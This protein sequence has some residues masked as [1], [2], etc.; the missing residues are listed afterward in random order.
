MFILSIVFHLSPNILIYVIAT[1]FE[2]QATT[3]FSSESQ[4]KLPENVQQSRRETV[5]IKIGGD[6]IPLSELISEIER[7][8][9]I[10]TFPFLILSPYSRI[11]KAWS[12]LMFL[13]LLYTVL[14]FPIRM[15]FY[16]SDKSFL[17]TGIF[18]SLKNKMVNFL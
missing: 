9:R 8:P 10:L 18:C 12:T 14:I 11:K 15:A 1:E 16:D 3:S 4:G 13:L 6:F 17:R 5:K 2:N 7:N